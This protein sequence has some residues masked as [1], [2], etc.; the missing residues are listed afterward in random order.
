MILL[1]G[2]DLCQANQLRYKAKPFCI[3]SYFVVAETK[4]FN[5]GF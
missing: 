3:C 2:V 1:F 4:P 5:E